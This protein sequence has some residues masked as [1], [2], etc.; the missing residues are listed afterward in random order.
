MNTALKRIKL[1]SL[2]TNKR[3]E[4]YKFYGSYFIIVM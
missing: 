1:D 2:Q 3:M 4:Y